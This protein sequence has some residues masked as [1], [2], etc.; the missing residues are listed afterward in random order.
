MQQRTVDAPM[1]QVLEE[2]VEVGKLVPHEQ[3]QQQTS[4]LLAKYRRLQAKTGVCS[5]QESWPLEKLPFR[6]G[7]V[8]EEMRK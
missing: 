5:V 6:S 1:P 3:A 4:E 8:R 7:F 2:T